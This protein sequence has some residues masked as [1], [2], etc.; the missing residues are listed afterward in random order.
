LTPAVVAAALFVALVPISVG[1]AGSDEPSFTRSKYPTE[2]EIDREFSIGPGGTLEIDVDDMDIYIKESKNDRCRVEVFLAGPD[3]ER[4]LEYFE[5]KL[6]VAVR[7][8]G[9]TLL[10]ES[11]EAHFHTPWSWNRYNRVRVWAIVSVPRKFDA[12]VYTEDGDLRINALDGVVKVRSEDGDLELR[13]LRGPSVDVETCDGD[14]I[15]GT[16]DA[17]EITV[18]TSD[19]DIVAKRF[20][21]DRLALKSSDGDIRIKRA[22]AGDIRIDTSDGDIE[23]G[24]SGSDLSIDCSDGDM[25][26][27]LFSVMNV[28]LSAADGDI[29]IRMPRSLDVDLNLRGEDVYISGRVSIEGRV[30]DR[31]VVGSLNNGGPLIRAKTSDGSI[32]LE[33]SKEG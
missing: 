32:E 16:F 27:Q 28:D 23:I 22:D 3:R 7:A 31:S 14:I 29:T 30:S 26:V 13:E 5:E 21:G 10:L 18:R 15:A 2:K 12:N 33:F 20:R 1:I 8:E 19:G 9:N 17:D 11:N 6:R 4:A 24:A 25:R